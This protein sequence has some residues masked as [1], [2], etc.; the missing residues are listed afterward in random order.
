M[1]KLV[2]IWKPVLV[3]LAYKLVDKKKRGMDGGKILSGRV[4][5]ILMISKVSTFL[6]E[7]KG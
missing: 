4:G 3:V 6:R 5:K 1:G 2:G 7:Y